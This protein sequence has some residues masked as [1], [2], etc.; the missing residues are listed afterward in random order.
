MSGT[1]GAA[2]APPAPPALALGLGLGALAVIALSC[3]CARWPPAGSGGMAELR[4]PAG[5][6]CGLCLAPTAPQREQLDIE[7]QLVRG[8]LDTLVLRGAELCLPGQVAGARERQ[9]R[10][11]RALAGGLP[12]DAAND[13]IVQ[14]E[15]LA[16]LERRLDYIQGNGACMAPNLAG[17]AQAWRN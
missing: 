9:T 3:A 11:A 16:E 8:H 15:R 17:S 4:P 10:I 14:R 5:R 12:L 1:A 2:A 13:L 6:A 7:L